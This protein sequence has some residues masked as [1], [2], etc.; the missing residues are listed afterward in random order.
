MKMVKSLLLGS[1]AGLV[2]IAGAQ[3]ADLPVKAKPVEY[4]KVC[5]AYG[6]GFYYIPGT[7]ICL[8]VGG[9]VFI[10]TGY[11]ARAGDAIIYNYT[12]PGAV[13]ATNNF[14]LRDERDVNRTNF[15]SRGTVILD[16]RSQTAI[17]T[18]RTYIAFGAD[19]NNNLNGAAGGATTPYL[20][21]AFI[22]FAGFTVGQ[23]A[24]FFDF[25][26]FY[27]IVAL[28]SIAWDWR[29]VFAYTA[30]FG[31]GLSATISIEDGQAARTKITV[32]GAPIFS[33]TATPGSLAGVF[34]TNNLY[35]GQQVPDLVANLRVD[36]AWGSAQVSGVLHQL[37]VNERPTTWVVGSPGFVSAGGVA[38]AAIAAIPIVTSDAWGWAVLGGIEIKTPMIAPGDSIMLQGVYSKGAV[39]YTGISASPLAAAQ[40]IGWR[41][42]AG[43]GPA[44]DIWDAVPN[45]GPAAGNYVAGANCP[46]DLT[47]AWSFNLMFRHFWQPNLRSAFWYGYN[48]YEPSTTVPGPS[49]APMNIHQAGANVIWSPV[50]TLDLSLDLLWTRLETGNPANCGNPALCGQSADLWSAWTRWRRNF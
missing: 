37:R 42:S 40:G 21:R 28:S 14:A 25:G 32:A 47:T 39:E 18:V 20:E 44:T 43:V 49:A 22:Q 45:C 36:Q 33:G 9:Y 30:Q 1:A 11:N 7:D 3:A 23:A 6:A 12:N 15:R 16:A 13:S 4:V 24:T 41:N 50:P 5:S 35:G 10:E 46:L 27:S 26:A 2:A 34:T 38:T 31:N 19:W 8:R 29:P 48:R 17:G